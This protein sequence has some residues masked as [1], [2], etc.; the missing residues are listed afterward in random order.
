[1][2]SI[3]SGAW[4]RQEDEIQQRYGPTPTAQSAVPRPATPALPGTL[5]I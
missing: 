1:M 4:G 5:G 2:S 3:E